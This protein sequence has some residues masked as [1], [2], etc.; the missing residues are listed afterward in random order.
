M[1][2]MALL[3]E[4]AANNSETAFAE[5]VSRRIGFVHSAALRQVRDPHLAGEITQAVFIILAQKAGRISEKTILTGWFFR[6]TRFA[7]L[8][9]LRAA[10]K[11]SM[12][13]AIVE[14]ELQ[15][16]TENSSAVP[17]E[18]WNQMSPLLDE[19]LATLGEKDR[20]AV[21]LRFFENKSLA[22]IGNALGLGEDTAR[23]RV[24]RALVKLHRYFAKRG[25]TSTTA[26]IAEKIS[27]NS[28][29][30]VPA[31]LANTV[32]AVA[33]AKGAA[34]SASTLTL[35]KGA[36]KIMAW[37]KIKTI[38]VIGAIVLLAG[39]TTTVLVEK[40]AAHARDPVIDES[41]WQAD[42]RV[43]QKVPPVLI[44]RPAKSA[45]GGSGLNVGDK[46]MLL[47]ATIG[48]LLSIAYGVPESQMVL[49]N[50]MPAGHF[51]LMLT[52]ADH[53]REKLQLEIKKRF[54]LTAH[55]E[56]R[57]MDTLAL[58]I[59]NAGAPG[60]T[61]SR[62][63][64]RGGSMSSSM[65]SSSSSSMSS[66]SGSGGLPPEIAAKLPADLRPQAGEVQAKEQMTM[67]NQS[68]A[69][70]TK[71]LEKRFGQQVSDETGTTNE[72]DIKLKV[73]PEPGESS[74]DAF[75]RC[76]LEQL[77]LELAPTREPVQMLVVQKVR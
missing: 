36:L 47:N 63:G 71:Y 58:K 31:A 29:Q 30:A 13:T 15:M 5:L 11:C 34:A 50:D 25:V 16:Q 37:T 68:L 72:F 55:F 51:D 6:T 59:K 54:G 70:F 2:D 66:F 27:T 38:G 3:R 26:T 73:Q 48:G 43:F 65:S 18:N 28:I 20:Q 45:N 14:K 32:T 23:K 67:N 69:A 61:R 42:S 52:L 19:A 74:E 22:D 39:G 44:I 60:L 62:G 64:T 33:V 77:G 7:A 24:S 35:I 75:K 10:A 17:D 46:A 1:D 49:P 57:D 4:Y 56:T 9:H 41:L 12:R 40:I 53:P 76:M 8:A 21:L